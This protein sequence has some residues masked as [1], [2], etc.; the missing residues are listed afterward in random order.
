MGVWDVCLWVWGVRIVGVCVYGDAWGV[1]VV[2]VCEGKHK[3]KGM[4]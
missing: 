1:C 4:W 2:C 3:E